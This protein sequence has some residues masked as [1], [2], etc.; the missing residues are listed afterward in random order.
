[1]QKYD[2]VCQKGATFRKVLRLK[3]GGVPIDLTGWSAR[4]QVREEPDGG[5]LVCEMTVTITA[6]EGKMV[7]MVA[8]DVT[9]GLTAGIYAWDLKATD[10]DGIVRYYVGGKFGVVPSVT[11]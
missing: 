2:L 6:E 11:E 4:S 10:A 9:A 1:M 5:T 3:Q 8:D 7:L